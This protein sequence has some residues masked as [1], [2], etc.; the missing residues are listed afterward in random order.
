MILFF[1]SGIND[2]VAENAEF[3]K[4]VSNCIAKYK[5][6]DWGDLCADDIKMNET[7]LKHGGRI[8]AAYTTSQGKVYIITDDT[9]SDEWVTTIMFA[10]EY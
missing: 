5:I 8:L 9:K 4:E 2:K 3:A 6:N 1:T 10:E 7:A